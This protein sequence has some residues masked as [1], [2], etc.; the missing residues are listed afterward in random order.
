MCGASGTRGWR[1]KAVVCNG[2]TS[3]RYAASLQAC[4]TRIF[5]KKK[6]LLNFFFHIFASFFFAHILFL[7]L[8]MCCFAG[9]GFEC[10]GY[11]SNVYR[12]ERKGRLFYVF[13]CIEIYIF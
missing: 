6:V 13:L 8:C 5:L 3:K 4:H 1:Q 11:G 9:G 12:N 2:R 7:F 10:V